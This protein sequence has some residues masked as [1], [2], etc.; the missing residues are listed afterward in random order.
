M[1]HRRAKSWL[2]WLLPLLVLRLLLPSGV[3]PAYGSQGTT[4]LVLCSLDLVQTKQSIGSLTSIGLRSDTVAGDHAPAH[5]KGPHTSSLCPFAAAATPA[6]GYTVSLRVLPATSVL[7]ILSASQS[8][9]ATR[10]GP[11]R[12]QLSRAPPSFS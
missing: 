6:P 9:R 5:Q 8:Q 4:R 1:T 10:S 2:I 7:L 12:S 11:V 3:M